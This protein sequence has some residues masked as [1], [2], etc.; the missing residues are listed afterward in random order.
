M[1]HMVPQDSDERI[2]RKPKPNRCYLAVIVVTIL[3]LVIAITVPLFLMYKNQILDILH[4][5]GHSDNQTL[6]TATAAPLEADD[7]ITNAITT[8]LNDN[9]IS[10]T[11]S[12]LEGTTVPPTLVNATVNAT[13]VGNE[14]LANQTTAVNASSTINGTVTEEEMT[15]PTADATTAEDVADLKISDA[16]YQQ[17][18]FSSK[19]AGFYSENDSWLLPVLVSVAVIMLCLVVAF[20]V[21]RLVNRVRSHNRNKT[22]GRMVTDLQTGDN[23]MILLNNDDT[24]DSDDALSLRSGRA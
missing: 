23:K 7:S 11:V 12:E 18:T 24:S 1:G 9:G 19:V 13:T 21:R 3:L 10:T 20:T 6:S 15:N 2:R 14:T 8:I 4:P 5:A 22:I 17:G 16:E